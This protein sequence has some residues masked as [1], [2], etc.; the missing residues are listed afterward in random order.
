MPRE[1]THEVSRLEAEA[2]V[3]SVPAWHQRFEIA[4]GVIT[5]GSYEPAFLLEKMGWPDDLSDR[6]V[7]DLGCSDGFFSLEARRRGA[8]VVAVDYRPKDLHGFEIMEQVSG[9]DF[10]YHQMNLYEIDPKAFGIFDIVIFLGV[11]YH[12]PDM[13]RALWV[14]RSVCAAQMFLETHCANDFSPDL[15]AARFYRESTLE[16]DRTNFWSPNALCIRDML[17]ETAFTIEHDEIWGT[18]TLPVAARTTDPG[19]RK[20]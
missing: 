5:P 13:V 6:R 16:N 18:V 20:N 10:E 14:I 11:L 15:A 9:L 4:P 19:G 1:L 7:L 17:C 2:L 3:A 8:Q 12:L